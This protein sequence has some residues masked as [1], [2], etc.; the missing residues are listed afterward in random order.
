MYV[1]IMGLPIMATTP[2]MHQTTRLIPTEPEYSRMYRGDMKIPEP[3][4][5]QSIYETTSTHELKPL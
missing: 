2:Q 4:S 1:Y 5:N 3:I